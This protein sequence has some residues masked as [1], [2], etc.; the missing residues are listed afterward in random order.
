MASRRNHVDYLRRK[1]AQFRA[2]AA[3]HRTP[4][5]AKMVEIADAL[6]AQAAAA[7]SDCPAVEPRPASYRIYFRTSRG[8]LAGREEFV[9]EDDWSALVI[10]TEL[11]DACSDVCVSFE[12][13]EGTRRV[14]REVFGRL[15]PSSAD[16]N[17]RMQE[18]VIEREIMMRDSEWLVARSKRLLQRIEQLTGGAPGNSLR[19]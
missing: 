19:T 10:A 12:L 17:R 4:L 9:A 6:E 15:E 8:M 2:L 16:L 7:K 13:W 5:S 11:V 1:A 3:D 18:A 14:D